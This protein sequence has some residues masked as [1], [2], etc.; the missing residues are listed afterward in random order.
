MS[1][2]DLLLTWKAWE[3][4]DFDTRDT[5]AVYFVSAEEFID[6]FLD[7]W[8][9]AYGGEAEISARQLYEN[10]RRASSPGPNNLGQR[11]AR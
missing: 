9:S 5:L 2:L 11:D 10:L 6:A 8:H 7:S 3:E 4:Q 1:D